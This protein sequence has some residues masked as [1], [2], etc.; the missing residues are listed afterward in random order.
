MNTYLFISDEGNGNGR[1]HLYVVWPQSL[2]TGNTA[3]TPTPCTH[4]HG[5]IISSHTVNRSKHDFCMA[6]ALALLSWQGLYEH[7]LQASSSH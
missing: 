5:A 6:Q 7:G 3:E 2:R 1:Y 4:A